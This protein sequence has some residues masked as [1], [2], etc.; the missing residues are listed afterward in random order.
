LPVALAL[1]LAACSQDQP[2]AWVFVPM[3][4]M[5]G[6]TGVIYRQF[7]VTI[8]AASAGFL[9]FLKDNAGLGQ[10]ALGQARS[11]FLGSAAQ[12]SLLANVRPNGQDN[13]P[14]FAIDV[15]TAKAAALGVNSTLATAWGGSYIDDFIDQGRVKRVSAGGCAVQDG[16]G[17]LQAL[18][19]AQPGGQ[20]GAVQRLR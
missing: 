10:E 20:D 14:Q 7:S 19:G 13:T 18:V 16:A 8:V 11:Q 3:A 17:G 4:F 15:D 5:A 6:S 9:F 1:A 2:A 12:S